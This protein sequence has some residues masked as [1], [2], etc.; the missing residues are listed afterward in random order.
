[1]FAASTEAFGVGIDAVGGN[2][3][4]LLA[5]ELA[6]LWFGDAVTPATWE[7]LWLS[8]GFATFAQWLDA[9]AQGGPPIEAKAEVLGGTDEPV[10]SPEAAEQIGDAVYSGG[11]T[12][13][14][15]LRD[16]VGD[17]T[18]DEILRTWFE[19]FEGQSASTADLVALA[20]EVAGTDLATWA[21]TWL[22]AP[23]P[24]YQ[25]R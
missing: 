13:L 15:A 10:H 17:E 11:A 23:Q 7:D 24:P 16:E 20:S 18:F 2:I 1:M 4:P 25:D 22:E 6:H 14:V 5:H 8:E 3:R 21:D 12:A 19:T 9:E